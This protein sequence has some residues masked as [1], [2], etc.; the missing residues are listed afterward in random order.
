VPRFEDTTLLVSVCFLLQ[1]AV[2]AWWLQVTSYGF[3]A[4]QVVRLI[5]LLLV[6]AS[7]RIV[8]NVRNK[9]ANS[10]FIVP[11]RKKIIDSLTRQGI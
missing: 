4:S 2:Q 3:T 6:F 11:L 9:M 7:Q 10:E 8:S 1:P 5:G